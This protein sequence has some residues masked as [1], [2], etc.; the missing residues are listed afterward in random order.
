MATATTLAADSVTDH[1]ARLHARFFYGDETINV[2]GCG[3][4]WKKQNDTLWQSDTNLLEGGTLRLENLEEQTTYLFR[5]YI[6]RSVGKTTYGEELSFTTKKTI[7]VKECGE[8]PF[9]TVSP[10]PAADRLTVTGAAGAEASLYNTLGQ[11]VLHLYLE[12]NWS[13]IDVSGLPCG[14][15][16]LQVR[17][18]GKSAVRKVQVQR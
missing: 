2:K 10:V 7:A 11:K 17:L 1:S 6:T 15:Y 18:E 3:I 12:N 13:S 16:L 9:F 8:E 14:S 4:E 5:G